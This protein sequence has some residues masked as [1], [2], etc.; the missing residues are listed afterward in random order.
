MKSTEEMVINTKF[1]DYNLIGSTRIRGGQSLPD[2]VS[3]F[4]FNSFSHLT[5]EPP[6]L[7]H[8]WPSWEYPAMP[9]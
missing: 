5:S 4:A 2:I 1:G 9:N 8:S 6:L 7:E 3:E